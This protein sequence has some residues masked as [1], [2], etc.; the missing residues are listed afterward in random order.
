MKKPV[1][2]KAMPPKKIMPPKKATPPKKGPAKPKMSMMMKGDM[3]KNTWVEVQ[4]LMKCHMELLQKV[5]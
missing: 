5:Q 2:K 3:A 4:S 1:P